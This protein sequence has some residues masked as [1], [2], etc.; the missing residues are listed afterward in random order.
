MGATSPLGEEV[1]L[2]LHR[3]GHHLIIHYHQKEAK[4]IALADKCGKADVVQGDF[5]TQEGIQTFAEKVKGKHPDIG[6]FV[7]IAGPYFIGSGLK[8][9]P[10]IWQELFQLNTFAPITLI[11]IFADS[12][13]KHEGSILTFG[14]AGIGKNRA[15][16][17]NTAYLN[18]KESLWHAVHSFAKELAARKVR[19]N[20]ISPGHLEGSVDLNT[21]RSKLPMQEPVKLA[22]V[23]ELASF[24]LSGRAR[25]ITGQN[26]EVEGG[27]F[28]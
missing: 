24:L 9:P 18:S 5:K 27:A 16:C 12:L 23:A 11:Q 2:H 8:T 19:V 13:A 1:C 20:M 15:N 28:L 4:A 26:I 22:A 17:Y 3:A 25:D 21:F 6:H 14:V 10:G 7:Y